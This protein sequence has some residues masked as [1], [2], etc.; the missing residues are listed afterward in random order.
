MPIRFD[1]KKVKVVISGQTV[2]VEGPKGKVEEKLP[3]P[4][5][6]VEVKDGVVTVQRP[7]D[8]TTARSLHGLTRAVIANAVKGVTDGFERKLDVAGVG[9]KVEPKGPNGVQ[10]LLGFSH[11]IVYDLPASVKADVDVKNNTITLRGP[12]KH[13]LGLA[14]AIIRKFRKAEPYKGKGV[15]YDEEVIRRKQG[16]TG[17]TA[18]A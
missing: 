12:D 8:T 18:G 6:K 5:F 2:K 7:S 14:A 1:P 13:E 15:R 10:L 9:Y 4:S 11:P 17:A 16:K 3:H